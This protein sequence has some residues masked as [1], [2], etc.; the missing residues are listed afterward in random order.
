MEGQPFGG[1]RA[2]A[3]KMGQ[4]LNQFINGFSIASS[5]KISQK[6]FTAEILS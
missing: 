3:R 5:H 4:L 6:V 1:L 2:N